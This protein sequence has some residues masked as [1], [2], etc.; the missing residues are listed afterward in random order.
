MY[1]G[2]MSTRTGLP[3]WWWSAWICRVPGPPPPR[4]RCTRWRSG[5]SARSWSTARDR[6]GLVSLGTMQ[7][8]AGKKCQP[9]GL[10]RS[11]EKYYRSPQTTLP[12]QRLLIVL[13]S[14]ILYPLP[15][16]ITATVL[17]RVGSMDDNRT[18]TATV[19][20]R[21]GRMDDNRTISATVLPWEGGTVWMITGQ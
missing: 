20:T 3:C 9:L 13:L 1:W 8:A 7:Y 16:T 4:S 10:W 14:F 17:T 21:K 6:K 19:L 5:S 12:G 18:I 2:K 11:Q 15:R